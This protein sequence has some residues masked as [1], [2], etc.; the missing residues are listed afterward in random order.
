MNKNFLA[1]LSG[2]LMVVL[3][4][5]VGEIISRIYMKKTHKLN[6]FADLIEDQGVTRQK[7]AGEKRV[8]I[9]GESA[10]RGVPYSMESSFSGFLQQLF[11]KSGHPEV[12]IVN[13]GIPGRHSFYHR[14]EAQTLIDYKAD[15]VILYAGNNDTRDFS[16]VMRDVPYALLDFKLFWNSGLYWSAK[17]KFQKMQSRINKKRGGTGAINYNQ[18]DV[19]HWTDL[20]LKK[21]KHYLEH[22]A[23]GIQ[24]KMKAVEDYKNNLNAL[25]RKLRSHGIDVYIMQLPIVHEVAPSIGDYARKGYQFV[26][27][28]HFKSPQEEMEWKLLLADGLRGMKQKKF[29][30]AA[31]ALEKARLINAEN[32][33]LFQLLG[34]CYA[35][36]KDFDK[37]RKMYAEGKDRQIQSPGG[38]SYKN[39]SLAW[40]AQQNGVP[41][42]PVQQAF[43]KLSPNGLVGRNLFLDH[44]HPN[45]PGHKVLAAVAMEGLCAKNFAGCK[46]DHWDSYYQL[47]AGSTDQKSLAQEYLL[48]AFYSLNGTAWT[49]QPDYKEALFYL[50]KAKPIIPENADLYS[51]L[52]VVYWNLD[53]KPGAGDSLDTLKRLD[54]EKYKKTLADY[55]YLAPKAAA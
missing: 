24:R 12:K 7:K 45:L 52:A 17:R 16:N 3:F 4:L 48:T 51:F 31:A 19:W 10:V 28:P 23:L 38:D 35:E 20:Y 13:T 14:E 15:A 33:F 29:A 44:C 43:E 54:P 21:K 5:S 47:L 39:E 42:V 26:L 32:P 36:L 6:E 49:P 2:V 27:K 34:E 41:L 25:V 9:V 30:E 50:E 18:D 37:S 53:N 8:F 46:P 11:D 1:L 55:P 22:P 40:I